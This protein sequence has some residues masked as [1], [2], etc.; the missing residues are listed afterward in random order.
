MTDSA[1]EL[2][3]RHRI[4]QEGSRLFA[5]RGYDA[6]S[7]REIVEAAGVKKPTLYYYFENK[8]GLAIEILKAFFEALVRTRE[9][10]LSQNLDIYQTLTAHA[11]LTIR[12]TRD[13]TAI[14]L[15]AFSVWLGRSSLI[16][17]QKYVQDFENASHQAW[18]EFLVGK[19]LTQEQSVGVRKLYWAQLMLVTLDIARTG[20]F[21]ENI[22]VFAEE[23]AQHAMYGALGVKRDTDE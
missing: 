5:E 21:P 9:E 8:E 1:Q 16:S 14:M 20:S 17:Q 13:N 10:A 12:W 4:L 2:D 23:L 22:K 15:F 18:I 3:T 11:D 6:V 7:V 19:G